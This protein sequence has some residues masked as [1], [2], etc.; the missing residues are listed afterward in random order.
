[1]IERSKSDEMKALILLDVDNFKGINDTLGHVYG[2]KV[3]A[4]IGDTLRKVFGKDECI[5]R[6][7]GDEF[8]VFM[9]IPYTRRTDCAA[10]VEE[11]CAALCAEF[12]DS[13][14]GDKGD[15]K[16]SVSLGA[17]LFHEHGTAFS[18]LYQCADRALYSSKHKGKDTYT[19]FNK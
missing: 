1:M 4:D 13:Y 6:L 10:Y 12:K 16:I 3:L 9:K 17:S 15:Y 14:T 19:L 8:C 5:G 18:K 7:G 2:D 11:K